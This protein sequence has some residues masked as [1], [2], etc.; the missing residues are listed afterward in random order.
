MNSNN[1]GLTLVEL[2]VTLAIV[3][4]VSV[5]IISFMVTAS[6]QYRSSNS[7]INLQFESQVVINQIQDLIIDAT[8]GL[9]YAVSESGGTEIK[10]VNDRNSTVKDL[11]KEIKRLYI[12]NKDSV[13]IITW[14]KATSE[15]YYSTA[16]VAVSTVDSTKKTIQAESE[17]V[18][19]A[20]YVSEFSPDLTRISSKRS[21][22]IDLKFETGSKKYDTYHNVSLRNDIVV[23]AETVDDIYIDEDLSAAVA[24]KVTVIPGE[25]AVLA[26]NTKQF[27]VKVESTAGDIL[28]SNNVLWEVIGA[29]S[30]GT[31]IDQSG[32]L[33]V[34]IDETAVS[35]MVKA[36]STLYKDA[37]NNAKFG[38]A[39]VELKNFDSIVIARE[40]GVPISEKV[41]Q[42]DS[43]DLMATVNFTPLQGVEIPF[44]YQEV[45]WS[46]EGNPAGVSINS[47]TGLLTIS[48]LAQENSS[49]NVVAAW[50]KDS[51]KTTEQTINIG[52]PS[53]ELG[54]KN[55]V[56]PILN[57]NG[58]IELV[59]TVTGMKNAGPYVKW[60][61]ELKQK[62]TLANNNIAEPVSSSFVTAGTT[63]LTNIYSLSGL[64]EFGKEYT[65]TV[66]AE[67]EGHP[68]AF[69][70]LTITIKKVSVIFEGGVVNPVV[71]LSQE[72]PIEE[73]SYTIE[74]LEISAGSILWSETKVSGF[75]TIVDTGSKLIL[76][77]HNN[78]SAAKYIEI[79]P[80]FDGKFR[81]ESGM[82]HVQTS[83]K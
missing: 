6:N 48:A 35:V 60:S 72:N 77:L 56:A 41:Y 61:S 74:G 25:A 19:M 52:S 27:K 29:A 46:I 76:S 70:E 65:L 82:M 11:N 5:S 33:T 7:E 45:I 67:L 28:P 32:N 20:K 50:K 59:A 38:T 64:L 1:K 21:L 58:K 10:T 55:N 78:A 79:F 49:I 2:V 42:N 14:K 80:Y 44:E 18:L 15:L 37:D 53:L 3:G 39:L 17:Q 75:V 23:N 57:R 40:D 43:I 71:V 66:R 63:G 34:G 36:T 26:G 54:T 8:Q 47:A 81:I 9:S 12:Y 22:K 16:T 31:F 73:L 4:L 51:T 24:E 13:H 68:H 83:G 30:T 62:P 69:D